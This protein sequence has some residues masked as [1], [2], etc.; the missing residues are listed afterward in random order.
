[1]ACI[2]NGL[3]QDHYNPSWQDT[4]WPAGRDASTLGEEF[5]V[6]LSYRALRDKA[7]WRIVEIDCTP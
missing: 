1:M 5:R 3:L 7:P 4:I 2:P 6:R